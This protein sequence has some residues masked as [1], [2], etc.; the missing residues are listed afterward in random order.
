MTVAIG[1]GGGQR[2]AQPVAELAHERMGRDADSDG[3]AASGHDVRDGGG[4]IE[5]ET[6]TTRPEALSEAPS[7]GRDSGTDGLKSK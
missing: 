4:A 2:G 6:E 1:T 5:H 7:E 3:G